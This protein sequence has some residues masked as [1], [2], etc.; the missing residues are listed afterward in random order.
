MRFDAPQKVML[1]FGVLIAAF[2]LLGLLEPGF[3]PELLFFPPVTPAGCA[4]GLSGART[5]FS[6]SGHRESVERE[7]GVAKNE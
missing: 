5:G 1:T 2:G 6:G 3:P 7:K 4:D